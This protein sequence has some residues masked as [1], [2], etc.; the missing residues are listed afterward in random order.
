MFGKKLLCLWAHNTI[1]RITS[2][3]FEKIEI[4]T[5][6]AYWDQKKLFDEKTE[7]YRSTT[8][9]LNILRVLADAI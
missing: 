9:F 1:I 7:K 6:H 4:V 8:V 2:R 5:G 3:I